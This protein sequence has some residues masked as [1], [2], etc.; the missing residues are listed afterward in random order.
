MNRITPTMLRAKVDTLNRM[1]GRNLQ[2][3][4]HVD[5]RNVASVG[6]FVLT[7]AYGGW[8]VAEICNDAGGERHACG[9]YG[10]VPARDCATA[11]DAALWAVREMQEISRNAEATA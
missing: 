2:A 10:H 9:L 7:G 4:S 3:Y 5:G 6:T 11:L 1:L 8:S